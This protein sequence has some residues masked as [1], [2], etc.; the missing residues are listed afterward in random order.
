[1]SKS[2]GEQNTVQIFTEDTVSGKPDVVKSFKGSALSI[3]SM[4]TFASG[5]LTSG[6]A[7]VVAMDG[8]PIPSTVWV[9]PVSGDTV[10]VEY[11]MDGGTTYENWPNG[12]VTARAKDTLN[13]GVTQLRFSRTVGSGTTS[14]Y[15][16]S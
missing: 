6:S 2:I 11:S 9:V 12:S 16:V 5:T 8:A 3:K 1:M 10:L 7:V 14:T 4:R 15:G 13:S